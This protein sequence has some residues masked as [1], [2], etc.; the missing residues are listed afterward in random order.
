MHPPPPPHQAHPALQEADET[1]RGRLDIDTFCSKLAPHLGVDLT[2]EQAAQL[3]M[4]I[5]AG[6]LQRRAIKEGGGIRPGC[7]LSAAD[8]ALLA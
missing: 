6:G 4:K 3:F 1:G 2:G 7:W 5:D 8:W